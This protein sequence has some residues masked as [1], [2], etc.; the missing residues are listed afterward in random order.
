[1]RSEPVSQADVRI[2]SNRPYGCNNMREARL[3]DAE[4]D[5]KAIERAQ[6]ANIVELCHQR[7]LARAS[8]LEWCYKHEHPLRVG[9]PGKLYHCND[10]VTP[11]TDSIGRL[12]E[13]SGG[14]TE[15]AFGVF[16]VP[17]KRRKVKPPELNAPNPLPTGPMPRWTCKGCGSTDEHSWIRHKEATC[18]PCGFVVFMGSMV[19]TH[20]EKMGAA[21][22]EDKTQ[23]ADAVYDRG[24]DRFDRPAPTKEQRR[25]DRMLPASTTRLPGKRLKGIG[26]FCD[27]QVRLENTAAKD[28]LAAEVAAGNAMEYREGTKFA[29][30]LGQL[31]ATFRQLAPVDHV[32]KRTTRQVAEKLWITATRHCR[33]CARS[34]CC[35]LRLVER[36]T[37]IIAGAVFHTTLERM[38]H[39]VVDDSGTTREHLLDLQARTQRSMTNASALTQINTAKVMINILQ[40]PGFDPTAECAPKAT[41]AASVTKRAACPTHVRTKHPGGSHPLSVRAPFARTD[42]S[43]SCDGGG[44]PVPTDVVELRDAVCRVFIAHNSELPVAVRDGASRAIQSPGFSKSCK[45]MDSLRTYSLNAVAFCV[46]NAVWREQHADES[47]VP[48]FFDSGLSCPLNVGVA[49][50]LE[51]DLAIAEQAIEAIRALV[52]TDATSEA[53]VRDDDDDLFS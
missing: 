52:P 16:T 39:G 2:W 10:F 30:I 42:S 1:M 13:R 36:T 31:D 11:I 9:L 34:D 20:R 18:C 21:A 38:L 4:Q 33:S 12:H 45:D 23:H 24:T 25:M 51:I 17:R 15:D 47:A 19:S 26:R 50:K 5:E 35:E 22:A 8:T 41:I 3:H 7:K 32:V 44:S 29:N 6:R 46:L 49:H 43:M 40:A 28:I 27:A 14:S 48:S 53:S 37:A